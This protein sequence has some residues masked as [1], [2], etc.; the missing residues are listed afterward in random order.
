M[1]EQAVEKVPT[2]DFDSE[3]VERIAQQIAKE[4]GTT[5]V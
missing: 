2:L 1:V 5:T 4:L 3:D